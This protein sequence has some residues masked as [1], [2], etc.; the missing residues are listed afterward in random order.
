MN[1]SRITRLQERMAA[2]GIDH[3]VISTG[4][5]LLYLIGYSTMPLERITALSVPVEGDAVLFVPRLEAPR[6]P[7][8]VVEVVAWDELDD[9]IGMLADRC[10]ASDAIAIGDHMWS[11]FLIR[12]LE[13]LDDPRLVPASE[14]TRRLREVKDEKEID[15]LRRAGAAVDRVLARLPDEIRFE[16]RTERQV[17]EDLRRMV[18]EEGHD[19]A[20][21]AIVAAGPNGASPHHEPGDRVISRGDVVVCDF[22]GTLDGY[23]SDVTRTFSVGEPSEKAREVHA[24]VHQANIAARDAVRPGVPCQEIDRTA[25]RVIEEAGYGEWFIHRTG[26]GIGLEVHEHPYIVEGNTEELAPGNAFSIEPGIYLPGE[27]GV[28]IE[29]IV[30][31]TTDGADSLNN[32]PRDLVVVG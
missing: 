15:A 4:A 2:D 14:L 5:D 28:R 18:V 26:H 31:C 20:W 25:R 16:G 1:T 3:T 32:A 8:G 27:F 6:V 7:E 22:G 13:R 29:D 9:P 30:V 11:V 19:E 12:L 17:A 10:K 23:Y 24:L 21:F